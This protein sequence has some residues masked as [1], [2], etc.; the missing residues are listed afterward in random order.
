M[1]KINFQNG[2]SGNTPL[3][4]TNLNK[5]QDNVEIAITEVMQGIKIDSLNS[6]VINTKGEHEIGADI[7]GY[8]FILF[9]GGGSNGN[10]AKTTLLLPVSFIEKGYYNPEYSYSI[11]SLQSP[12]V[13]YQIEFNF[14]S[15]TKINVAGFDSSGW[16]SPAIVGIYGIK[17][18][19]NE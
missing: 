7:T 14:V 2:A 18:S 19:N 4:A 13:Y 10:Y 3:N 1:E 17:L 11:A 8:D 6:S 15:N 5:L 12:N 16:P 9:V